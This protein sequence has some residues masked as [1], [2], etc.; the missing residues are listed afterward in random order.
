MSLEEVLERQAG[1]VTLAQAVAAGISPDTVQRRARDGRWTRLH[2]GVYLV[3]GHRLGGEALRV[4]WHELDG[5]PTVVL[6]EIVET[7][8]TA[9]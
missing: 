9:A 6:A 4:T 7:V 1:V 3:G 8:A 2:P 5:Q